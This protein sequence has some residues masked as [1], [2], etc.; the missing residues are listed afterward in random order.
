V[1]KSITIIGAILGGLF[2]T[3][4]MIYYDDVRWHLIYFYLAALCIVVITAE[5]NLLRHRIFKAFANF[6]IT[7]TGRGATYLF[8]GG[9]M[10][11][12]DMWG[13]IIGAIMITCGVI[14]MFAWCFFPELKAD[15]DK[16]LKQEMQA[17][18]EIAQNQQRHRI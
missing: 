13:I 4:Q 15:Q 3:N 11:S 14:N 7:P 1:T 12:E 2:A 17:Q 18:Q 8:I 5:F 10:I 9:L 6:L 16:Y